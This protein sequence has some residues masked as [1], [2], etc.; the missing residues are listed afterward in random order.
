MRVI[1]LVCP[2]FLQLH[3]LKRVSD[4]VFQS[5]ADYYVVSQQDI[6]FLKND[7]LTNAKKRSRIN[8][9]STNDCLVH[10]MIVCLHKSTEIA[11]H[12][13]QDKSESFHVLHGNLAVV[14][15]ENQLPK[16]KEIIYLS[17]DS[18]ISFYRLND[19]L[20]HLVVPLTEF[21]VF[22]ETTQGPFVQGDAL[23]PSWASSPEGACIIEKLRS[24]FSEQH[25]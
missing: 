13:H 6:E 10:E 19:C 12:A 22:H 7:C 16:V 24:Q 25:G 17:S 11:V 14:L 23:V 1:L 3:N 4:G 5:V 20:Y 15:F 9:H 8:C 18:F 2:K 21:C